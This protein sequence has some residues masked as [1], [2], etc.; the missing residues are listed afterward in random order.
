V[1]SSEIDALVRDVEEYA[2]QHKGRIY[3]PIDHPAFAHVPS[4]HG[5][6]R[7]EPIRSHMPDGM[8]TALDIGTHWGYFA[9]R[10]EGLGLRVT[11]AEN[12]ESY[13]GFLRRIRDLYED[14]FDIYAQSVFDLEGDV[15]FDVVLA[16]NIF[17]HFIK[18]ERAHGELID[19]LERLRCKALFFQSHNIKEGQMSDAFRN[20]SPEKFCSVIVAHVP[21][22]NRFDQ[23]AAFGARPMFLLQA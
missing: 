10:L 7:F 6:E 12:M 13:L 18:T 8:E 4:Q 5:A 17:H 22:L 9:H 23:I 15:E 2:K 19:F 14:T 11:A 1:T 3:A 21:T 20:Y 16:L